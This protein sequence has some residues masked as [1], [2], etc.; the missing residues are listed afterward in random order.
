MSLGRKILPLAALAAALAPTAGH[1]DAIDGHWCLAGKHL[2]IEG[3]HIVTPAGSRMQ[4]DYSR[5]AFSYRVPTN[6]GAAG[7]MV[8]MVLLGEETMQL[9]VG[10]QPHEAGAAV[11]T[12]HRCPAPTS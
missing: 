6:E 7:A 3:P 12:W 8:W 4:G 11:E 10:K 2:E 1:A 9:A 5:H